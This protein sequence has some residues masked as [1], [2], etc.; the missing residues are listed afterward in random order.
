MRPDKARVRAGSFPAPGRFPV[1]RSRAGFRPE[2]SDQKPGPGEPLGHCC[3]RRRLSSAGGAEV[4][5][6]GVT[7][8]VAQTGSGLDS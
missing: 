4:W 5:G 7:S 1:A 8:A 6:R 3:C 2:A